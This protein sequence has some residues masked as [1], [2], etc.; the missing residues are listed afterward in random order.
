MLMERATEKYRL[1]L[2]SVKM[3]WSTDTS[4]H[5]LH[6][7]QIVPNI[8]RANKE[9][10]GNKYKIQT[11]HMKCSTSNKGRTA[12]TRDRRRNWTADVITRV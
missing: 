9:T 4:E 7:S 12:G 6:T 3:L 11:L 10:K 2:N 8:Y 1:H 5:S